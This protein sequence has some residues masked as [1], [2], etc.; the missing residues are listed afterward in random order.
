MLCNFKNQI[1]TFFLLLRSLILKLNYLCYFRSSIIE[2]W[3]WGIPLNS[4][5]NATGHTWFGFLK[6]KLC[7]I[8]YDDLIMDWFSRVNLYDLPCVTISSLGSEIDSQ[9]TAICVLVTTFYST[10]IQCSKRELWIFSHDHLFEMKFG[11]LKMP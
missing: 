1:H 11:S 2:I 8:S 6:T 4:L 7:P 3:H 5:S 10:P 9:E